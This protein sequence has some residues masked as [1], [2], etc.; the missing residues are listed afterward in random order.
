M[1]FVD[2]GSNHS[3]LQSLHLPQ[4][5]EV[6]LSREFNLKGGQYK[7]SAFL[8][9]I[10]Q[11]RALKKWCCRPRDD[12]RSNINFCTFSV[13]PFQRLFY[14]GPVFHQLLNSFRPHCR[15]SARFSTLSCG[16]LFDMY[17][18]CWVL[19]SILKLSWFSCH[20]LMSQFICSWLEEE[21][22]KKA[23][24]Q[25]WAQ[26]PVSDLGP[27]SP[28]PPPLS[29]SGGPGVAVLICAGA[30]R[31]LVGGR[32]LASH[33]LDSQTSLLQTPNVSSP[34]RSRMW[35][36]PPGPRT[37][38]SK[39]SLSVEEVTRWGLLRGG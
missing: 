2:F 8:I 16:N 9:L 27:F 26:N 35:A 32:R 10:I 1:R 34:S 11:I 28:L 15:F 6:L 39:W 21:R 13:L 23:L 30:Q 17:I 5:P 12:K 18:F 4:N 24:K 19:F 29:G 3:C 31:M 36:I 7:K 22:R 33:H 14:P 37:R 38:F 20:W 25:I